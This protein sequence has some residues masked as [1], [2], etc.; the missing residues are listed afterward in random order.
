MFYLY[1]TPTDE[2]ALEYVAA[3]VDHKVYVDQLAEAMAGF[4]PDLCLF[5]ILLFRLVQF[6]GA[7]MTTKWFFTENAMNRE[8]LYT[9][10]SVYFACQVICALA[11]LVGIVG[12]ASLLGGFNF[13]ILNC[14][15]V[16]LGFYYEFYCAYV[17][18]K[19]RQYA[20]MCADLEKKGVKFEDLPRE[21]EL[22]DLQP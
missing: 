14:G 15:I 5:I 8:H 12:W 22:D 4:G 10:M 11:T 21:F 13:G 6:F 3:G 20:D 2:Q 1:Q 7:M 17:M 9:G 18:L 16:L 19:A